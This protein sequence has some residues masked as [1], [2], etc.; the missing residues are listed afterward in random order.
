MF[1]PLKDN[2][3]EGIKKQIAYW[4]NLQPKTQPQARMKALSL[5]KLTAKLMVA[6]SGK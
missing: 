3:V 2:S 4:R 5:Y 1:F 6:E